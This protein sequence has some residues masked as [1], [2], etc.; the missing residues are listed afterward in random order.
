MDEN[1]ETALRFLAA[2]LAVVT[3]TIHLY[4]G[5]HAWFPHVLAGEPLMNPLKGLFVLSSIAVLVGLGLAAYGVRRDYLYQFGI[6]LM[7][8]YLVGWLLL[9][10]HPPKGEIYAPA[11]TSSLH[12]H[13]SPLQTLFEHLVSSWTLTAT[14]ISEVVVLGLLVVLHREERRA[15]AADTDAQTDG[16]SP[17]S[18]A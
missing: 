2:Q 18:A 6:G 9:G 5:L 13:G 12:T 16:G 11:W 4:V 15:M 3:A 8:C 10:G 7:L 17:E 14:K 1:V